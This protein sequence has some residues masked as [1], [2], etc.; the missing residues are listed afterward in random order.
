MLD[1][2]LLVVEVKAGAF[3]PTSP[4]TDFP[5]LKANAKDLFEKPARQANRLLQELEEE[6]RVELCDANHK[7]VVTLTAGVSSSRS[8]MCV[9]LDPYTHLAA[10]AEYLGP[11]GADLRG[12]PAWVLSLDDLRVYTEILPIHGQF[13]H[14]MKQRLQAIGEGFLRTE[15]ELVHLG[16]YLNHLRYV[17]HARQYGD[18]DHIQWLGYTDSV[19]SYYG[20]LVDDP[21]CARL[22]GQKYPELIRAILEILFKKESPGRVHAACYLLDCVPAYLQELERGIRDVL[23]AQLQRQKRRF[24]STTN[25]GALSIS[26]SQDGVMPRDAKLARDHALAS[27]LINQEKPR[28][29]LEL[30]F[31]G[32]GALRDVHF[33]YLTTEHISEDSRGRLLAMSNDVVAARH[34]LQHGLG[35]VGRNAPCGCGSGR[36]YK[37]CCWLLG[38]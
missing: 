6:D 20:C 2:R 31:G 35:G 7:P 29:L 32:D 12:T 5:A 3:T 24:L 22:P 34:K 21:S 18:A 17:E 14:Y 4:A 36:K 26:C 9:T 16:L 28:L 15:D 23:V 33:E 19:D 11:I 25:E 37:K 38:L 1:D 10:Q 13:L 30:D 27:I 8:A